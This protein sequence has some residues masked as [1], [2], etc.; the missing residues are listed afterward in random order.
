MAGLVITGKDVNSEFSIYT[1]IKYMWISLG[2]YDR[3]WL[4]HCYV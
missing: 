2:L 3:I 4:Q 1:D